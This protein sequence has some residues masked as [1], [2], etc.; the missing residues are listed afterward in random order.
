MIKY[1]R[2]MC[3]SRRGRGSAVFKEDAMRCVRGCPLNNERKKTDG[4]EACGKWTFQ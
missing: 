4:G 3:K 2:G 1:T